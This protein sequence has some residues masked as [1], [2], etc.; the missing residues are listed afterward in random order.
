MQ[1]F[2]MLML[3]G[4]AAVAIPIIIQILTRKN[5]RRISWGAWLFLDKTMKKRRRKVLLEDLL[6]LACRCL[7]LALLAV[8]HHRDAREQ[9][10]REAQERKQRH[11][12]ADEHRMRRARQARLGRRMRAGR[13]KAFAFHGQRLALE[14]QTLLGQARRRFRCLVLAHP[15]PP[16]SA[17]GSRPAQGAGPGACRVRRA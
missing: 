4:L 16:T 11:G 14:P 1:F 12:N 5:V 2:N 13:R 7:A 3:G 6:L 8:L 17:D 10:A 9:T 15:S